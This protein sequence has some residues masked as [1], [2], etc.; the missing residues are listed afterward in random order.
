M[1][2]DAT[3]Y[4]NRKSLPAQLR[5]KVTSDAESGA[6]NVRDAAD[7]RLFNSSQLEA[8]HER[9]GN[10]ALVAFIRGEIAKA[11]GHQESLLSRK[12]VYSGSHAGDWI[13]FSEID[14]LSR[15]IDDLEKMT[16]SSRSAE[17]TTFIEQMRKLI[18][19]AIR[20]VNGIFF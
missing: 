7:D 14:Q 2:L 20:E 9:L 19:A 17:L 16:I 1:G 13:P 5:D 6:M 10:I 4:R 3:V 11:L 18:G 8:C 15:E 12:V